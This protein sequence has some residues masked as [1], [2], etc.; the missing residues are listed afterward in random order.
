MVC[1]LCEI[2]FVMPCFC[3]LHA[4]ASFYLVWVMG[5]RRNPFKL[6]SV[7]APL[8]F[9]NGYAHV[10]GHVP[11]GHAVVCMF[12]NKQRPSKGHYSRRQKK[13]ITISRKGLDQPASST[14]S[15]LLNLDPHPPNIVEIVPST[16]KPLLNGICQMFAHLPCR[17]AAVEVER[18]DR[19]PHPPQTL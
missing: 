9:T 18:L 7:H 11:T 16:L 3:M 4:F 5:L 13:M 15:S 17:C 6:G 2:C 19:A 12:A 14:S 10:G 1:Q 8:Y